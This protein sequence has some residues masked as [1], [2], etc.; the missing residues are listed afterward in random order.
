MTMDAKAAASAM[1]MPL[2][3]YLGGAFVNEMPLPLGNIIGGG[4]HALNST[5][6]QEF[7]VAGA[8]VAADY[9]FYVYI[10]EHI[11]G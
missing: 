5:D 4:A 1:G 7:L 2:F 10:A 9:I 3:R 8:G 11:A 6:I